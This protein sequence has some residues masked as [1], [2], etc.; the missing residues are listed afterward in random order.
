MRTLLKI[1]F[2]VTLLDLFV[3][4][5]G[6]IFEIGPITLRMVLFFLNI[7]I[8]AMLYLERGRIPANMVVLCIAALAVLLFYSLLGW[9]NGAPL[10]L[11]AEDVKPLSYF[12]SI[13]FFGYYIDS[14]ERVRL[15]VS[16]LKKSGLFMALAYISIQVLFYLGKIPFLPFYEYVNTQVSETDFSFRG[17]EGLFFYKG[18]MYMVVGLIFWIHSPGSK[19]KSLAILIITTAMILTGTRGFIVMFGFVYALFYGIPLLL[20]LN[21]KMLILAAVLIFGSIFFFGSRDIGDKDL[22]DSIRIQQFTQVV[23]NID[24]LTFFIGHGFGNGV[25]IRPVHMEIAYLETFHKQ[26]VIGLCLWSLFF[27]VLYNAYV[28]KG[29]FPAIR[30]A[31]F[32]SLL[33]MVL[34]SLTNPFFNN[35][36]GISL[37]MISLAAFTALNHMDEERPNSVLPNEQEAWTE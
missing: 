26:G 28:R 12:F 22:S 1:I 32:L 37:F 13:L 5:G 2:A 3:G 17:L 21:I 23:Q 7:A 15:V 19:R 27:L 36:I 8:V 6:R 24:P 35:P 14:E 4:G 31:F 16:L 9:I 11:I 25:P 20:K 10:A 30:R 33:F 18:F 29:N 34:L